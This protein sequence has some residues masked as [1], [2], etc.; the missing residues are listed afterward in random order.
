[1]HTFAMHT[2]KHGGGFCAAAPLDKKTI[3][4]KIIPA[5]SSAK[6]RKAAQ[7]TTQTPR[8]PLRRAGLLCAEDRFFIGKLVRALAAP[9]VSQ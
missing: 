3:K 2:K 1:M 5:Q 6:W 9:P 8:N 7:S 4:L